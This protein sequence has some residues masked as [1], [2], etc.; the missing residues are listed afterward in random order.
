MRKLLD[1]E[2]RQARRLGV[3]PI[4]RVGSE[5][6]AAIESG[7]IKWAVTSKGELR[8]MPKH[9]QGEELKHP[10]LSEGDSVL[11]AGEVDISGVDG[12]YFGIEINHNS[13]HFLPA[14]KSVEIGRAAFAE[15][16]IHF[17]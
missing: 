10:V 3:T 5:F 2:L 16:G 14:G 15:W 8:I 4:R 9:V 11:A 17:P 12:V 6:D 13:G 7:T 1:S